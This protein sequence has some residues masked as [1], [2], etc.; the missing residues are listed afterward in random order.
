[1]ELAFALLVAALAV[2]WISTRQI[3]QPWRLLIWVSGVALLVAATILV[4][5]QND[6]VGL[7][8]AIGNLWESRDS[9]SSGILVQAFRRNVGGVAQ[10]VPQLM[11]VFLAAGAVLAAAAFA[12]FTPGERTE[13]LVRP[14][15]LGTL[16]FM[17]GG[18]VSL[19]V[20]AIGFGGYVKPRTHLGYVSDA[21]VH[22]GDSFYIGEIP[23]RLWGADAPESDQE[24]SNGT[25]CGELAR[26]HLVELMD[27]ALIQCDQ[28][29]SQRT[30]RPRDSFGRALVQC[31]AW[32]EREP[33]VDLAEQMIREG[34]AIQ[35][36]GRD[37]GY[38]DAEAD[39]GSRNLMLTC[40]LRPDRWRN[41][42][43]ARLLFEATRT[44]Q[45]GV[46]TMGA[47]P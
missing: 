30:Q 7:F 36:E 44:V 16:A 34:Y 14:L 40:T 33:R 46:R 18:V 43:E 2:F 19:S 37:Y 3:K 25:D 6:H 9:P 29:L 4:F 13:R 21:N 45:E 39:G 20:V 28:R 26:T 17:L 24:C 31:W 42:D 38:S 5:R 23:M 12:A 35:Y 22:D 11:D 47:C 8:R 15:I 1:M 27:G 10:F 41:D 32:R